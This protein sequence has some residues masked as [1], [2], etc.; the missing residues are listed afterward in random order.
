MAGLIFFIWQQTFN[1][2]RRLKQKRV[3]KNLTVIEK[4]WRLR[5]KSAVTKSAKGQATGGGKDQWLKVPSTLPFFF[6][7][8]AG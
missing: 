7:V 1:G 3:S 5:K 8:L 6:L 2:R 4:V